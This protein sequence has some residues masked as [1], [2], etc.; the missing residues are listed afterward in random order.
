MAIISWRIFT[1]TFQIICFIG[2]VVMVGFW[3]YKYEIE[4]R[5]IGVVD[6]ELLEKA[7]VELPIFSL[8]FEKP[9]LMDTLNDIDPEI[10]TTT[11]LKYLEGEIDDD[12]MEHIN[13][14]N[15]TLDL[16]KYFLGAIIRFPNEIG[17]REKKIT[18][19][20]HKTIFNGMYYGTFTKCF[21]AE[22]RKKDLPSKIQEIEYHYNQTQLLKYMLNSKTI[23]SILAISGGYSLL[24]DFTTHNRK[25]K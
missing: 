25:Q 24:I 16:N 2:V 9:V 8:C 21:A 22:I 20:N 10:N 6:Y 7:D 12:R 3:F 5:D 23:L 18:I 19:I 15:V 4:D 14:F 13:Y 11:Y 17:Y 1:V